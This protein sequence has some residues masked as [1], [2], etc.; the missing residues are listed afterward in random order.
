MRSWQLWL[1]V[2]MLGCSSS[3]PELDA[4]VGAQLTP[5][6]E[7]RVALAMGPAVS[8]TFA[9]RD[10]GDGRPR[11]VTVDLGAELAMRVGVPVR[12]VEYDNS[13]AITDAAARG[14]WDVTFVPVDDERRRRLDFGPAYHLFDSTYLVRADG[15]LRTLADVD[16]A[17]VRVAA[18]ANTTT[19][20]RAAASLTQA[21]L[22]TY[23]SVD[24]LRTLILSGGADAIALSRT[25]LQSLAQ[26]MP[27]V[28]ILDEAFHSSSVAVAVPKGHTAAL[29][30]VSAFVE[31]AK[32]GGRVRRALDAAGL[33]DAAVAPLEQA[34]H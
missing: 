6:G 10:P 18:I 24:E 2:G 21:K 16:R 28:R 9:V 13:G 19:G 23:S 25:S 5:T 12:Y 11:G 14:E 33:A 7:L 34:A 31:D 30:Y 20:R 15:P 4:A 1:S 27:G 29:A 32:A 26:D 8:A 3:G 17:G 22:T